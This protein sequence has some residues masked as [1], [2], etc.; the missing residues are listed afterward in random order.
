MHWIYEIF[1]CMTFNLTLP[2]TLTVGLV[3]D[4]K[5]LSSFSSKLFPL[6]RVSECQL[7]LSYY[8]MFYHANLRQI[9]MV[10][11]C[12]VHSNL[13]K[14]M[15]NFQ[16]TFNLSSTEDRYYTKINMLTSPDSSNRDIEF[17]LKVRKPVNMSIT[18]TTSKLHLMLEV[19]CTTF[20]LIKYFCKL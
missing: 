2:P 10:C 5:G 16:Y 9:L 4:W 20:P 13:D 17:K 8:L 19:V 1:C 15:M 14:L 6:I 18:Y 11:M 12:F 3:L 7:Y